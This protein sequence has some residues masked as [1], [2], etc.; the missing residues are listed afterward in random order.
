MLSKRIYN[1]RLLTIIEV[2]KEIILCIVSTF[3]LS[4]Q[5]NL[6]AINEDKL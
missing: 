3:S 5:L 2:K 1:S 4:L 6:E